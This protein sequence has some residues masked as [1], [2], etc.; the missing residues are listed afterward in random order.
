MKHVILLLCGALALQSVVAQQQHRTSVTV[1]I[2]PAISYQTI[3]N[4]AASDAWSC[5]FAGNW[6]DSKRNRMADWLFSTDTSATGQPAGIG[7][8]MWRFNI[9]AGSAEQGAASGI[10]DEWRRA[11]SLEAADNSSK[12]KLEGQYWFLQAAL[13]RGVQQFLGFLN[14]PPVQFTTNGKAFATNGNCN[15]SA[16][17][18]ADLSAYLVQAIQKVKAA[19]GVQFNYISP[20]NEPQWDWSDGGQEGCPYNNEQLAGLVKSLSATFAAKQLSTRIL[21][22]EAG[23]INYLY[24]LHDKK[25]KGEQVKNFFGKGSANYL[26]NLPNV[27]HSIAAHS[28][29]TTSPEKDQVAMRRRLAA[30]I[31]TIPGLEFWQ[32]EYCILGDND[33]EINGSGKDLGMTAAL[34]LARVIHY[35]LTVANAA[36]WQYWLAISPYDYKDALIYIDK[37]ATDGQLQDSKM[38]WVLGNYSRFIRPGAK[39]IQAT[40]KDSAAHNGLLVSGYRNTDNSVNLVVVNSK[41]E[42]VDIKLNYQHAKGKQVRSYTTSAAGSLQP[43]TYANADQPVNIPGRSVVTLVL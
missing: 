29:F 11:P 6:P 33:G 16:D 28:Y 9:G 8:S 35:D 42:A 39:R 43:G 25:D 37:Q 41:A 30:S 2:D 14:S 17:R 34:Y 5:Q 1:D 10:K 31:A 13:Q 3:H 27:Q 19:T 22:A 21:V 18:Y 4:F 36:A 15:I 38:L 24:E 20:V 7:L 32:S 26:G 12:K 23:K 40:V